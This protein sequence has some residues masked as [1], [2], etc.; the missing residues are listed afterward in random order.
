MKEVYTTGDVAKICNVTIRTVIKWFESGALKGFKIPNSRDR[1]IPHDNLVAFM[2]ANDIP[3]NLLETSNR[4]RILIADDEDGILHVLKKFLDDIGIFDVETARS[5]YEAGVKTVSFKPHVL[6]LDH[7]LG[8]TTSREVTRALRDNPDLEG[9]KILV[10]SGYL[11]EDEV[12]EMLRDG[13]EDFVRKPFDLKDVKQ[14]VF[15]L[16]DLAP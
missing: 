9:L 1:R 5:G 2:K 14:R 6:I 15:K 7:L 11:S 13:V 16:L 3:L 10:M 8:D 4:K 12:D